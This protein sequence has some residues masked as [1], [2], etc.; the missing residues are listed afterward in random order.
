MQKREV[1]WESSVTPKF[2][3]LWGSSLVWY[4]CHCAQKKLNWRLSCP[5]RVSCG[6]VLVKVLA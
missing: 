2:P 3:T 4:S 1:P 6:V 5:I